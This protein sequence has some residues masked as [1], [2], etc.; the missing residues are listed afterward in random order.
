MSATVIPPTG[1]AV[2]PG[3]TVSGEAKAAWV[4]AGFSGVAVAVSVVSL[5]T[6]CQAKDDTDALR[7]KETREDQ[8]KKITYSI[9]N[10]EKGIYVT[11]PSSAP[12]RDIVVRLSYAQNQYRYV[13][14]KTL[15]AC[16]RWELTDANLKAADPQ[17]PPLPGGSSGFI[18]ASND[19]ALEISLTDARG[20]VWTLWKRSYRP[21]GYWETNYNTDHQTGS[22]VQNKTTLSSKSWKTLEG[23]TV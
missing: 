9:E 21:G 17:L 23:C 19:A 5:F 20:V 7:A 10:S 18:S 11:N 6:S 22:F 3:G 4:S 1:R 13:T 15:E 16:T 2:I 12:I 14:L 8:I